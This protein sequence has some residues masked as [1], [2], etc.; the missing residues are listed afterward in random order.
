MYPTLTLCS[1]KITKVD[2]IRL[3]T[4][5]YEFVTSGSRC[6]SCGYTDL[7]SGGHGLLAIKTILLDAVKFILKPCTVNKLL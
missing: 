1:G 5:R 4:I 3:I 6:K 7:S 2:V